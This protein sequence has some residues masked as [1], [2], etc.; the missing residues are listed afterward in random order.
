MKSYFKVAVFQLDTVA[1][2]SCG[3]DMEITRRDALESEISLRSKS[4]TYL[5]SIHPLLLVGTCQ[6][7]EGLYLIGINPG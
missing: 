6:I 2:S 3:M 4:H 7:Q 1:A 5:T